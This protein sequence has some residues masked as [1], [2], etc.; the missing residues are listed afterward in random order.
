MPATV[1]VGDGSITLQ[2]Q[3]W[4]S[5]KLWLAFITFLVV[6]YKGSTG[7]GD[8]PIDMTQVYD[9]IQSVA[10][11]LMIFLPTIGLIAHRDAKD[12]DLAKTILSRAAT[13]ETPDDASEATPLNPKPGATS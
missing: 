11:V 3:W 10:G 4:L 5:K 7:H 12:I 13:I 9:K 8:D 2:K 1:P 6:L